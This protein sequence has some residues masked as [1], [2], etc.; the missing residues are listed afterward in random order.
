MGGDCLFIG[1]RLGNSLLLKF[2]R[3]AWEKEGEQSHDTLN[4]INTFVN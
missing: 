1:S 3:L 4:M 2:T